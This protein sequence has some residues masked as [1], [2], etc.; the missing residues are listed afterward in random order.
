MNPDITI[1][2]EG[3]IVLF[4]PVTDAGTDWCA[5]HLPD[6]CP[7]FGSAFAIEHRFAEAIADGMSNDGL[8]LV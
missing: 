5:E 2:D 1:Q 8:A 3:T 6:D 4:T 7:R